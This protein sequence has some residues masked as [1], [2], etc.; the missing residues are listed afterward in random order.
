MA[1]INITQLTV[2]T[3]TKSPEG[4]TLSSPE[5]SKAVVDAVIAQGAANDKWV[6]SA[7][8]LFSADV[9]ADDLS[10]ENTGKIKAAVSAM[11]LA[12]LPS[13][14]QK[15]YKLPKV[16]RTADDVS[17]AKNATS[18][19]G[20]Y[21]G[22]IA[23]Y[24]RK[25]DDDKN[26]NTKTDTFGESLAKQVQ[27]LIDKISRAPAKKCNFDVLAVQS[28]LRKAKAVLLVNPTLTKKDIK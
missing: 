22:I 23:E 9:R 27:E 1:D 4:Y 28:E 12:A 2:G 25:M 13:V 15:A 3:K 7:S 14:E 17:H 18:K 20:K 16:G 24:L 8:L 11:I 26:G 6:Y 5:V 21:L 19:I 10:K